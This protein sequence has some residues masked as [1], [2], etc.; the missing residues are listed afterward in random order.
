MLPALLYFSSYTERSI[1]SSFF[2]NAIQVFPIKNLPV[3]EFCHSSV[4][5]CHHTVVELDSFIHSPLS[6]QL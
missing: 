4:L 1:L 5:I 6:N 2:Y 3:S